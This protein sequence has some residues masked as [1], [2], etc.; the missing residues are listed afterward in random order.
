MRARGELVAD[1]TLVA[2][3]GGRVVGHIAFSE[4]TLDGARA[5]GL[6]LAPVAVVPGLQGSG[7]GSQLINESL[8]RAELAGWAFVV[9]LGHDTYYSQFGFR[10][11]APLGLTGDY[12]DHDSWMVLPLG[13][14]SPPTGR[15]RYCSAFMA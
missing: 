4:V 7:L 14:T 2:A 3:V 11:A 6:G 15:V 8:S 13:D 5:G 12:G 9:L 1:L 10:P